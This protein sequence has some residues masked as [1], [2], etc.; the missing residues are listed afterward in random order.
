MCRQIG[1]YGLSLIEDGIGILTH[2]NAG[3]RL[4]VERSIHDKV[5]DALHAKARG[6]K[7]G[8]GLDDPGMGPLINPVP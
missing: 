7:L 2:C 6:L 4:V 3:T 5:V 1:E 8:K